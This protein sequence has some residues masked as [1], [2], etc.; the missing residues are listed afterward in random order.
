MADGSRRGAGFIVSCALVFLVGC[1]SKTTNT[2]QTVTNTVN[3]TNASSSTNAIVNEV[4]VNAAE[5][6]HEGTVFLKGYKTPSESF[7]ILTTSGQEIGLES[8]DS[9]KEQFRAQI[10]KRITVTFSKLC[11]S[12]LPDCC[13]TLFPFCGIVKSWEPTKATP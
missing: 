1:G 11:K 2:N 10:G 4:P 9:E 7:G 3:A 13:R 6:V 8:Y 5:S 12:N